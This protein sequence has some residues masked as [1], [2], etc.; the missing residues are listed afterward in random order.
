MFDITKP[1]R[2]D[3][4]LLGA[5]FALPCKATTWCQ[6]PAIVRIGLVDEPRRV[7]DRSQCNFG[8]QQRGYAAERQRNTV[9]G[10]F[11]YHAAVFVLGET[12]KVSTV[13][14]AASMSW[15]ARIAFGP[16]PAQASGHGIDCF[17]KITC[18]KR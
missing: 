1:P 6:I 13:G 18:V 8:K 7:A 17:E 4:D 14:N 5:K 2:I 12:T 11:A 9:D 10:P 16:T 15:V 3:L